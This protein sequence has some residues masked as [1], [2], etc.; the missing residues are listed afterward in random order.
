MT[1]MR[2]ESPIGVFDSGLG[3]LTVLRALQLRLPHEDFVYLGDT[4]RTP[5]GTRGAQTILNYTHVCAR[6][7]RDR[8]IKLLV[9]ACST[10]SAVALDSLAGELF[11]P[12]VG[13]IVPGA[14]AALAITKTRRIGVLTST[15]TAL[16]H[17]YE[18]AFEALDPEARVFVQASPLLIALADEGWL[19]GDVPRLTVRKYVEPLLA[20]NVDT[21][22][23]GCSQYPLL[24]ELVSNELA[25]LGHAISVV[26]SADPVADAALEQVATRKLAT[27]RDD[28]GKIRV[29]LTELPNDY[30]LTERYLGRPVRDITIAAVDL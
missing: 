7:L 11:L 24:A 8:R 13:S 21:L 20:E 16:T 3:G 23:L 26:N 17:A 2:T 22:L 6:E 10:V 25:A 18:R 9:V 12:V 1:F 28:P 19:T 5:Y 27:Q 14:Q 4:A 30:A 29:A 15:R